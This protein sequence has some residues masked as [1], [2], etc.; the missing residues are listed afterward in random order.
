MVSD[1]AVPELVAGFN[2]AGF[3]LMRG[4]PSD[5]NVVLSPASIGHAVLM[6]RAAADDPTGAAIDQALALPPGL[7]AHEAWNAIDAAIVSS[8]GTDVA[9]D[10]SPTPVVTVADRIWPSE[11]A[12]PDP[13]WIDL[14]AVY[15][16]AGVEA[17]DTARPEESRMLINGWVS[18]RTNELIPELLPEG[19][20]SDRTQL[21]LT[22]AVYFKA[23]WQSVFGDS[24]PV[25]RPFR[26]LDGSTVDVSL[27]RHLELDGPR[28]FGEGFSGTELPYLGDDYSM[29]LIIP[30]DGR[31]DEIRSNLSAEFLEE[32]DAAFS[33]GPYELLMPEWETT[34]TV[35]LLPW[36]T[37]IGAAPGAY[38]G[39]GP[40]VVLA[41]GVHGADITVDDIGTVAAAAT[42]LGFDDSGPPEPEFTIAA[43]RPFF[44][45]IRHVDTGLVLFA[46]QVTDPTS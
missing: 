37:D 26:R 13:A 4:S 23:Q 31:F 22:D 45:V 20:I 43:D 39:I 6:A 8:N 34:T 33:T 24:S 17:I 46:G 44:S 42:A 7:D 29:L 32:V 15:H 2:D 41:G 40:G 19:F 38:P 18:E 36:L 16:G 25:S 35:D 9:L 12:A 14:L 21:V 28:G 5:A 3:E 1:T 30:D 11:T 10:D 27:L